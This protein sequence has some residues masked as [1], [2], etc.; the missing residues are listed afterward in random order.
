MEYNNRMVEKET[1][2]T[3][4]AKSPIDGRSIVS[5]DTIVTPEVAA[6]NGD[7]STQ[8]RTSV[9]NG[10]AKRISGDMA[11]RN[12]KVD[13]PSKPAV[14]KLVKKKLVKKQRFIKVGS[15]EKESRYV[16]PMKPPPYRESQSNDSSFSLHRD[17][18]EE[19]F[20]QVYT[21]IRRD[22]WEGFV[23]GKSQ[24]DKP[25]AKQDGSTKLSPY[26]ERCEA[27][28]LR[29]TNTIGFRC[30]WCKH[31][32]SNDRVEKSAIYPRDIARIHRS[33]LR[34]QRDHIM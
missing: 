32:N 20:N 12:L 21:L 8:H 17:G 25:L 15:R 10:Y 9:D 30:K 27:R 11:L 18:D 16:K 29:Y 14:E 23:V 24:T 3:A 26:Y 4:T 7:K 31:V 22:I 33:N 5:M 19:Y 13:S 6:N 2:T 1:Q 28:L 34:F